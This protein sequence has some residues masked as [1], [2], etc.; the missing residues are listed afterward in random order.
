M[1]SRAAPATPQP[2]AARFKLKPVNVALP[3]GAPKKVRI[4]LKGKGSLPRLLTLLR[5]GGNATAR[6]TVTATDAAGN[7]KKRTV[8]VRLKP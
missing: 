6:L 2:Q 7:K 5:A 1:T 3:A 8:A 4:K